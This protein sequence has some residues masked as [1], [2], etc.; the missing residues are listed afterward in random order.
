[1]YMLYSYLLH[2]HTVFSVLLVYTVFYTYARNYADP[3]APF[4]PLSFNGL[5]FMRYDD[6]SNVIITAAPI[7]QY[8]AQVL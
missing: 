7:I 8:L 5:L 2:E 6:C 4:F 3:D 1:M